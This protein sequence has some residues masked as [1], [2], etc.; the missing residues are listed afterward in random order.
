MATKIKQIFDELNKENGS[1]YKISILEKHKNNELFKR[2]LVSAL[3]NIK[4]TY[5]VTFQN[6]MKFQ[7]TEEMYRLDLESAINLIQENVATRVV[8]GNAALQM[9]SN[10]F[11]SLSDDDADV[12]KRIIDRD[13]KC[14][15]GT[16]L[17]NKVLPNLITKQIYMR[18]GVFCDKTKNKIN[19]P[20]IIQLKADGTYREFT[21]KDGEVKAKSRSGE[22]YEYPIHFEKMKDFPD[23]VYTCE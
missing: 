8:T 13:L 14:N 10:I 19:F 4:F 3:D 22:S 9:C 12:L 11:N 18:C 16:S 5:G 21:V 23:G 17:V 7:Q 6:I 15:V 20:A 2:V 1:K